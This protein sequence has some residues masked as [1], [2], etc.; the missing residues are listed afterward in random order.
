[1][2]RARFGL[3]VAAP[4]PCSFFGSPVV[5]VRARR[6]CVR[7]ERPRARV[8]ARVYAP[9]SPSLFPSLSLSVSPSLLLLLALSARRALFRSPSLRAVLPIPLSLP[10]FLT[11]ACAARLHA[12]VCGPSRVCVRGPRDVHRRAALRAK[13]REG[14]EGESV[15]ERASVYAAVYMRAYRAYVCT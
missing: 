8:R 11:R 15:R 6:A 9:L 13:K 12:R 14:F 1:M 4:L 3:P 10:S 2:I 5:C 7:A